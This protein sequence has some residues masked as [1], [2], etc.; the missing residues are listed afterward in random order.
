MFT[1]TRSLALV[2]CVVVLATPAC[3]GPK[4]G[5]TYTSPLKNFSVTVPDYPMGTKVEKSNEKA[6]GFV[7]FNGGSGQ[8]GRIGYQRLEQQ[9][10][11]PDAAAVGDLSRPCV[12]SMDSSIRVQLCGRV[13]GL[14]SL[15]RGALLVNL[16]QQLP[17]MSMHLQ[18]PAWAP[19]SML[20]TLAAVALAQIAD[21]QTQLLGRYKATILSREPVILDSTVM[22]FTTAVSPGGSSAIDMATGKPLDVVLGHL[23]FWRNGYLYNLVVAPGGF[24]AMRPPAE[25]GR[26]NRRLVEKLYESITF[27]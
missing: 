3:G 24:A 17:G 13:A 21:A 20:V 19:D 9:P 22:I 8:V 16:A 15:S 5:E 27:Q 18:E 11:L 14:D 12:A 1:M 10:P 25:L 6:Y 4:P 2:F 23:V 7:A 26:T